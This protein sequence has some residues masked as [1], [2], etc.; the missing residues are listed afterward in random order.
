MATIPRHNRHALSGIAHLL[1]S[2]DAGGNNGFIEQPGKYRHPLIQ[3]DLAT[4]VGQHKGISPHTAS[5]IPDARFTVR[6]H[7]HR[8]T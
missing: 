4:E 6:F 2:A 3:C 1:M 5:R 7:S 8:T